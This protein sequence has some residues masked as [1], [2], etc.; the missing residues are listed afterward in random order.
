MRQKYIQVSTKRP[1]RPIAY[2]VGVFLLEWQYIV[3]ELAVS[4]EIVSC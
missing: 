2:L 1:G 3:R 4:R